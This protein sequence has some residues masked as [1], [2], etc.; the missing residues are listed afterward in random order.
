MS[1]SLHLPLP[2]LSATTNLSASEIIIKI[3]E[4]ILSAGFFTFLGVI[5]SSK[6]EKEINTQLIKS[7]I[8]KNYTNHSKE[9]MDS[10]HNFTESTIKRLEEK[11]S[12]IEHKNELIEELRNKAENL[13]VELSKLMS[14]NEV[15]IQQNAELSSI[16][17]QLREQNK[18]LLNRLNELT[19]NNELD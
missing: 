12:E 9:L 17:N 14:Q 7:E 11:E 16:N 1:L 19:N 6:K 10:Y 18:E 8:E 5:V 3:T 13:T 15:L 4:F 2:L